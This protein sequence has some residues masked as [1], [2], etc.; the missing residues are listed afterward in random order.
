MN[1]SLKYLKL[2]SQEF[3]TIAA[4]TTEIMNLEAILQLPKAT[5]HFVTDLHGEYD[6]FE[7]VL[8]TG[9]GNV[10]RKI[11]DLYEYNLSSEDISHLATLIY[12]PEEKLSL[13]KESCQDEKELES[14]YHKVLLLLVDVADYSANKYTRSKVRKALPEEFA[15]IIEELLF[16]DKDGNKDGY[17]EGIIN[18]MIELG[19]ADD[20]II[21]IAYLI[22]RLVVDHLHVVGDIYDRG[23]HPEKIIQRLKDYHSLDI[24]WGNHDIIWMGAAAGS[25]TCIAN[26][27]R[28]SARYDN[29]EIIE[30]VYGIPLRQLFAF[31]EEVYADDY[32]ASFKT[33]ASPYKDWHYENELDQLAKIQEAMAIIQFKLEKQVIDRNPDFQMEDR[34]LLDKIDYNKYTINLNGK[35]YD[36][37]TC[38]FPTIDP[39]DP[40]RLTAAETDIM[41]RLQQA[42]VQSDT[43]QSDINFLI[44]K[45]SL[46]L[47]YNDNLLIHAGIPMTEA[48]DYLAFNW[49]GQSY[50]GKELFDFFDTAVR[51]AF[52]PEK[53]QNH[54]DYLDLI[55]YLWTGPVSPLFAKHAMTTFERYYIA[56]ESTHKEIKNAYYTLR[57]DDEAVNGMLADFGLDPNHGH[58]INGHTPVKEKNGENPMKAGHRL[59]VIDGGFSKA[60]QKSTGIG[61]YTLLSNSYG[62][63]L[64]IHQPFTSREDAIVNETDILDTKRV[65][66]RELDRMNVAD[67]DNGKKLQEQSDDLKQLLQAYRRGDIVEPGKKAKH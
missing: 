31:A 35:T 60:Y 66:D 18:S 59:L 39:A 8:R 41:Q 58:I 55:W 54:Q 56:D 43:L 10:K 45:G 5:E 38:D 61:G 27:V 2:L 13:M 62:M 6:A 37:K 52:T 24:Q 7:H 23:P 46:Y 22:Q 33:K 20:F 12:Y 15:Y 34:L 50:K 67:T 11:Q 4:T 63:E 57:E 40:Y 64:A 49:Q 26:V 32:P 14:F 36:L 29:L 25:L 51:Q 17:Y 48:G 1:V 3:P 19:Q 21:A 65:V 28:I 47:K 53:R 44:N 42:F 16:R 9:S 30:D